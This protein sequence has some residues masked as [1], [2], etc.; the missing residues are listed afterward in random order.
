ME[1]LLEFQK[2]S[3]MI[4]ELKGNEK[5]VANLFKKFPS[6]TSIDYREALDHIKLSLK[7]YME[8]Q[9]RLLKENEETAKEKAKELL[10]K[11]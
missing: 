5:S 10:G 7:E 8:E 1:W 3:E 4:K 6:M 2:I 9:K 11:S